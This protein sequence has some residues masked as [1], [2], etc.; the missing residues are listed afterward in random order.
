M[1]I[2]NVT[3]IAYFFHEDNILGYYLVREISLST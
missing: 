1:I 3:L 2:S